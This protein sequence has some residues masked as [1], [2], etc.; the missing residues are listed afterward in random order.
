MTES[1]MLWDILSQMTEEQL[2]HQHPDVRKYFEF[3]KERRLN[4]IK[5]GPSWPF[6]SCR[7]NKV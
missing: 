2:K 7:V 3:Q 1:E 6:P 4:A 5:A